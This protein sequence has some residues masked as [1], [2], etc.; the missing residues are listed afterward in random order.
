MYTFDFSWLPENFPR[1][2][3][4]AILSIK[5]MLVTAPSCFA[6]GIIAGQMRLSRWRVLR[7]ASAI[8]VDLFRTTPVL[9]Q[10]AIFFFVLPIYFPTYRFDAFTAGCVALSL[11]YGA[12]FA[13]VFRAG[14]A[15]LGRAQQEAAMALGMTR[16]QAA[17]R[18]IYP[19]AIRRM[20]PPIGSMFV[21]LLKDTSLVSVIGVA[22]LMNTAQN[23]GA[24][25]FRNLEV[26]LVVAGIY[27]VM[28]YPI[29]LWASW[30][31]R[32]IETR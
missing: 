27:V 15:S 19:Q 28:T 17:R 31:H 20:M 11:N 22:E 29:A 12:F 24:V 32:R 25:T 14:V 6:I 16:F 4:G 3:Q 30:M 1:L 9:V 8:Y 2:I 21:S 23:V 7:V 10:L 13:E 26:L 18:I 5:L